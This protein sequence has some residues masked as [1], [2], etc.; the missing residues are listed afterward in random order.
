MEEAIGQAILAIRS[1][2]LGATQSREIDHV[3]NGHCLP[4]SGMGQEVLHDVS[5]R[6]GLVWAK[7]NVGAYLEG[8]L[9]WP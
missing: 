1:L 2:T 7:G 4:V 6:V 3:G 5:V 9:E 8:G